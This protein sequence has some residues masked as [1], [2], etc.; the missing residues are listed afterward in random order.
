MRA[1]PLVMLALLAL[2]VAS[3]GAADEDLLALARGEAVDPMAVLFSQV[4]WSVEPPAPPDLVYRDVRPS[5]DLDGDAVPDLVVNNLT[6]ESPPS[7][8]SAQSEI[9]ALSGRTGERIW[10]VDN[11]AAARMAPPSSVPYTGRGQ[12]FPDALV[13]AEASFDVDGDGACDVVA[14]G[15]DEGTGF[16]APFVGQPS[17]STQ[18]FSLRVLSGVTGEPLWTLDLQVSRTTASA[19]LFRTTTNVIVQG[20]PTG[21]VPFLSPDGPRVALKLT[22]LRYHMLDSPIRTPGLPTLDPQKPLLRGAP[23]A[24]DVRITEH[25]QLLDA[26]SGALLWQRDLGAESA[27]AE[28]DTRFTNLTWLSGV[29]ELGGGPEPDLVLDQL[30]IT[31]PRTTE[32]NH[33]VSGDTMFRYG[34]GARVTALDGAD[35]AT[36][37]VANLREPL[38]AEANADTEENFETLV[39]TRSELVPDLDG[40]GIDE[41]LASYTAQEE[42]L[43]TTV[44]GAYRTHFIPLSGA[45]GTAM[46]D[47]RQ[48]GWGVARAIGEGLLGMGM[49]D[50]P[51]APPEGGQLPP[52]F[53]R[54][55]AV[56][57]ATGATVWSYERT[58]AQGSL[59]SYNLALAQFRDAL[60][61]H[62]WNADGIRDL[63]TPAQEAPRTGRD[64][65][66]LATSSHT[67][68][69]LSGADGQELGSVRAW[70]PDG[71]VLSCPGDES[72]LTVLSGHG[73]RLELARFDPMSGERAWRQVVHNDPTPRAASTAI[74]VT[75]LGAT[76]VE[77]PDG[78]LY[79]LDLQAYSFDRGHEVVPIVGQLDRAGDGTWQTPRLRGTPPSD[80]LFQA[81]ID[82][83]APSA[84]ALWGTAAFALAFGLGA[85]LA[86]IALLARA[87]SKLLVVGLVLVLLAPG[88]VS[89]TLAPTAPELSSPF[90][91]SGPS[92]P[93][94]PPSLPPSLAPSAARS[95]PASS[96]GFP[97]PG[98][99]LA[100][101]RQ[102]VLGARAEELS[103]FS[104]QNTLTFTHAI[105]DVDGDGYDD[106]ALDQ[107]CRSF[108]GGCTN[109][110]RL[111][112]DV[113]AW[114]TSDSCGYVHDIVVV[115]GR[116]G[117]IVWSQDIT[118]RG[119]WNQCGETLVVGAMRVGDEVA[120]IMLRHQ[121][122]WYSGFGFD[123]VS[124][125]DVSAISAR[126]GETLWTYSVKGTFETDIMTHYVAKDYVVIPLI[127]GALEEEQALFLQSVGWMSAASSTIF[128]VIPQ[129]PLSGAA[130]LYD[131][132][133]PIEWAARLDAQTGAEVWK[134]DTF[135]PRAGINA[136]PLA[137]PV[138]MEELWWRGELVLADLYWDTQTCCG[139]LTGDGVQD[140]AFNVY[141]WGQTPAAKVEQP[142]GLD[143]RLLV[144]DGATGQTHLDQLVAEDMSKERDDGFYDRY[145]FL[146]GAFLGRFTSN[147]MH[148]NVGDVDA[149]GA[150]DLLAHVTV[151][152][153]EWRQTLI[154]LSGA[155]G[156]PLWTM[157]TQR[158]LRALVLGDADGDGGSD[159]LLLDWYGHEGAG[160]E[161]A[162]DF[163]TPQ[164]VPLELVSGRTGERIWIATSYAA[165]ADILESFKASYRNGVVDVDA[166][167]VADFFADD[168][169]YLDDQTVVHQVSVISGRNGAPLRSMRAVGAFAIPAGAGDLND[170]GRGE[171]ALLS[172]D[173]N[174][175]W[176][177]LYDGASG[178]ASW[179]RRILAI[180]ATGYA[181]ALPSMRFTPLEAP[182]D[183]A[184]AVTFHLAVMRSY[185]YF[186]GCIGTG[187]DDEGFS[188]ERVGTTESV[189]PQI[190]RVRSTNGALDWA[191]PALN[192]IDGEARVL[193]ATPGAVA[194]D[195]IAERAGAI[196][197]LASTGREAR[198]FLL[199]ALGGFAI[200]YALGL[201]AGVGVKR[202]R[203]RF[204]GVPELE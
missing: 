183:D 18:P 159:F 4:T 188:S 70:G 6:L 136:L 55:L 82:D 176:L 78:T 85:A 181:R 14:Y 144:L 200:A 129:Y 194:F 197:L 76:C 21:V 30:V 168:P 31:T 53:V 27:S 162:D 131:V 145:G 149:D 191:L 88:A 117:T 10:K 60:A 83:A 3:A 133:S 121:L 34:R 195:A 66:L 128:P 203:S 102:L 161:T 115:S 150:D 5:C 7:H 177:T 202:V 95:P 130:T 89:L 132:H 41:V 81:S 103:R 165:P 170:D 64:Q 50:V 84:L 123:G 152:D 46:W 127:Q 94:P 8:A 80:A 110:I 193:G 184:L 57:G 86:T 96:S 90:A 196:G 97:T 68:A 72:R 182:G 173:V 134:R 171:V 172:G 39:W 114:L 17:F 73:R 59:L 28:V 40:D 189:M 98:E 26:T 201:A 179:S 126:T 163:V 15:F 109:S 146:L 158:D 71:R 186:G 180:P 79:A 148:Q 166:D 167:G 58:F 35:G 139:D 47:V 105:G 99:Q 156:E 124:L 12:P 175:L 174:D 137:V 118:V 33:P 45:N 185:T 140:L 138:E 160:A 25:V 56:E 192:G 2:P 135:Q 65:V 106:L 22:D 67:Y 142:T 141:E 24:E 198:P 147:V 9:E 43:A 100:A 36:L 169:I 153:P 11:L 204:E 61:P 119:P 74:D 151:R 87:G 20:F 75:G 19:P 69:V 77:R 38:A 92:A 108:D 1:T 113:A 49:L 101:V 48:Q 32:A 62:D 44:S 154:L 104:D 107:Y 199:P 23:H 190:L 37:W 91:P 16:S 54:L 122:V 155:T 143:A 13:T 125:N 111:P 63:V 157:E 116:N 120:L 52:R 187:C 42:S 164:A 51:V 29:A 112:E 93:S 178:E